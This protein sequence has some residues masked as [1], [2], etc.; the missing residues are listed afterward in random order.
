MRRTRCAVGAITDQE[1][2]IA[3]IHKTSVP[4]YQNVEECIRSA[5]VDLYRRSQAAEE[6][7]HAFMFYNMRPET[8]QVEIGFLC[9]DD[10][11]QIR[12]LKLSGMAAL[13]NLRELSDDDLMGLFCAS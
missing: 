13:F 4:L 1:W 12:N 3:V 2:G 7:G 6:T 11:D 8:Y 9:T 5:L 10:E